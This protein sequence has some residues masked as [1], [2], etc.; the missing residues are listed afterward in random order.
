M[1]LISKGIFLGACG[2]VALASGLLRDDQVKVEASVQS[3][4]SVT[5]TVSN[6]DAL[7]W[8]KEWPCAQINVRSLEELNE[9]VR[10]SAQAAFNRM[11]DRAGRRKAFDLNIRHVAPPI[12]RQATLI[13]ANTF[14][15]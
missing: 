2:A 5:L 10:G 12:V 3:T 13:C 4:Q 15:A 7:V 11:N 1:A 8:K 6:N 9:D 14:S